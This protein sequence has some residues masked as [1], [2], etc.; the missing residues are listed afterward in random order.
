M[1]ATDRKGSQ[2]FKGILIHPDEWEA[3]EDLNEILEVSP[4]DS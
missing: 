3:I 1:L 2:F 4:I